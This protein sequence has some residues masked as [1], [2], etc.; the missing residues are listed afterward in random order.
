MK[1]LNDFQLTLLVGAIAAG[2]FAV[3][4]IYQPT[5]ATRELSGREVAL[6]Q[7]DVRAT[8]PHEAGARRALSAREIRNRFSG[9]IVEG[10][11]EIRNFTFTQYYG[12]DGALISTRSDREMYRGTWRVGDDD[13]LCIHLKGDKELCRGVIEIDGV[14]RKFVKTRRGRIKFV[15]T[16]KSF[17][18]GGPDDL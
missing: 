18:T 15:V 11:N 16:F 12:P 10:V 8:P 2:I 6:P 7:L 4:W 5:V 17:R 14:T 1:G 13:R 9:Q 3:I